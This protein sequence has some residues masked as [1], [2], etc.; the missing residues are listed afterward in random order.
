MTWSISA[1]LEG[2]PD[3]YLRVFST[4]SR[5]RAVAIGKLSEVRGNLDASMLK[6]IP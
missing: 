4:V 3:K 6:P 2:K 1:R 5:I